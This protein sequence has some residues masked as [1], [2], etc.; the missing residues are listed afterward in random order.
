MYYRGCVKYILPFTYD[1]GV[2]HGTRAIT[3]ITTRHLTVPGGKRVWIYLDTE[4]FHSPTADFFRGWSDI[5]L[6]SP[7]GGAGGVYG[8]TNPHLRGAQDFDT[9]YCLAYNSDSNM[10]VG[11]APALLWANQRNLCDGA[12]CHPLDLATN[13]PAFSP[14]LPTPCNPLTP[15]VVIYQYATQ[16]TIATVKEMVD[17]DLANGA[18]FASMWGP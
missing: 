7:Y 1:D 5:M 10:R 15:P 8:N 2:F 9:P 18:G 4:T 14:Q 11:S 17:F 16:L 3:D 13:P 12:S 6:G